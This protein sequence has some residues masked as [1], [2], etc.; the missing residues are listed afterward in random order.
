MPTDEVNSFL[1]KKRSEI[2]RKRGEVTAEVR[3]FA[4]LPFWA[5]NHR[6]SSLICLQR[7]ADHVPKSGRS[8]C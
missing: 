8:C 6:E 2:K 3:F 4:E 7:K 5:N 1:Q